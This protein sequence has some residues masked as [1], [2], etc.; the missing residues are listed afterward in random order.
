MIDYDPHEWR[1]HLFDIKGSVVS[2]IFLRVFFFVFCAVIVTWLHYLGYHVA[3][4]DKAHLLLAP[5]LSFLLVLRTNSS[6]ERFWEGRKMWGAIIN[7]TRNLGRTLSIYL[8]DSPE[9]MRQAIGWTIAFPYA[10]MHYLRG[11]TGIGKPLEDLPTEKVKA[12]LESQNVPLAVSRNLTLQ[13]DEA[14]RQGQL[15]DFLFA[16]LD[17]NVQLLIDYVGACERIHKTPLPFAYMVHLRRMLVLFCVTLPFA[18]VERYGW[19]TILVTLIVSAVLFGIEE[20]AVEI[21]DPF[22]YDDNDLPL[23]RFCMGI[24]ASLR[25]ILDGKQG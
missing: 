2:Q 14:R 6:Y 21:E 5:V 16:T 22:S 3:I 9:R 11:E 20:I 4:D 13:L 23:E 8:A 24:E 18:V 15:S 10:A 7:E 19:G 12:V 17:Q 25:A 1:D